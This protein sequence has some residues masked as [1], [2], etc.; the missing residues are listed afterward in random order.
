MRRGAEPEQPGARAGVQRTGP[1][2]PTGVLT[3]LLPHHPGQFF[4]TFLYNK[5]NHI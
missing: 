4:I 2:D 3:V 5:P 1:P